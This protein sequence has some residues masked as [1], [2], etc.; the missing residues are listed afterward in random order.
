MGECTALPWIFYRRDRQ[1]Q[2]CQK[3]PEGPS[4]CKLKKPDR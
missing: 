3:N 2:P 1:E 4:C